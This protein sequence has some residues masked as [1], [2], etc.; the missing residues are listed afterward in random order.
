[1]KKYVHE[2]EK[3][4]NTMV[5]SKIH[6]TPTCNMVTCETILKKSKRKE[7]LDK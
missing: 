4:T 6:Y 1:V 5:I 3:K 2:K 7:M